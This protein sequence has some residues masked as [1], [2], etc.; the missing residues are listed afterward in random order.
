VRHSAGDTGKDI[1]GPARFSFNSKTEDR[2]LT[3]KT[4]GASRA[5]T[6]AAPMRADHSEEQPLLSRILISLDDDK[7]E[8][9]VTIDL[10]GR[11]SLADAIVIASDVR[12]ATSA[13]LQNIWRAGSR[14][15]A[16]AGGPST[17][18]RRAIGCLSMRLMSLFISFRPRFAPITISKA[19]G[20]SKSP[21]ARSQTDPDS[22]GCELRSLQQASRAAR[23][24]TLLSMS[25]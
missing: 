4:T 9:V 5:P 13:R 2:I 25:I 6:K 18:W 15:P 22:F 24:K 23:R 11:S 20:R 19:C 12:S 3:R 21:A 17:G 1:G 8:D 7:A 16:T 14:R 10:E